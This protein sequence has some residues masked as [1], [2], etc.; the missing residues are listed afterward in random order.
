MFLLFF[1]LCIWVILFLFIRSHV[2]RNINTYVRRNLIYLCGFVVLFWIRL[3][4]GII[5]GFGLRCNCGSLIIIGG[6][7][8][9]R[10]FLLLFTI[11][12][13]NIQG[14]HWANMRLSMVF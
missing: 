2:L 14:D 1:N 8:S 5:L 10:H 13:V 9:N 4:L 12:D 6:G 7:R 3:F 11:N